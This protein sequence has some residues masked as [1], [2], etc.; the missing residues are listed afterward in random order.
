MLEEP[1]EASGKTSDTALFQLDF[2]SSPSVPGDMDDT[3][4]TETAELLSD[5]IGRIIEDH[6]LLALK[7]PPPELLERYAI[8]RTLQQA[9]RDIDV[10]AEASAILLRRARQAR[11]EASDCR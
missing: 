6:H 9:G 8:A 2:S 7:K 1:S 10:L 5:V 11:G 3:L 4:L